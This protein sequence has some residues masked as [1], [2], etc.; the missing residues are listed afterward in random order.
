[1]TLGSVTSATR[2][3][4]GDRKMRR[5]RLEFDRSNLEL[6]RAR[7][8]FAARTWKW[9]KP[10]DRDDVKRHALCAQRL[11]LYSKNTFLDDIVHGLIMHWFKLEHHTNQ[12]DIKQRWM[13]KHR[14]QYIRRAA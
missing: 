6:R 12:L 1:M 3:T 2:S 4:S 8:K 13:I 7:R 5:A 11:G 9:C 10:V 14:L